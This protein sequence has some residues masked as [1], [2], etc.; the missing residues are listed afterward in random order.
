M[1]DTHLSLIRGDYTKFIVTVTVGGSPFSLAGSTLFFTLKDNISRS[2]TEAAVSKTITSHF[3]AAGG[4]S[5]IE[6]NPADTYPLQIQTYY[7]DA[8]L[9]LSDGKVYTVAK[10]KMNVLADVTRR[11]V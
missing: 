8:Q 1:I 7:Y 5:H 9:K 10:G 2:D 4:I 11:T 6:L 3:D